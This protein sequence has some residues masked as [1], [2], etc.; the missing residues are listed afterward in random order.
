M[1]GTCTSGRKYESFPNVETVGSNFENV[2]ETGV[3][4]SGP[5]TDSIA[6]TNGSIFNFLVATFKICKYVLWPHKLK[7]NSLQ[8]KSPVEMVAINFS[9]LSEV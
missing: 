9:I 3:Y 7:S 8:A 5:G 1:N 2:Q 6:Y 4:I